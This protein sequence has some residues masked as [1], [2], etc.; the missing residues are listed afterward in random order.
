MLALN[1]FG[2]SLANKLGTEGQ[3]VCLVDPPP[4][5]LIIR[6]K[7]RTDTEQTE[8]P[9]FQWTEFKSSTSWLNL[10]TILDLT[11]TRE[12][13]P[14]CNR[15]IL[16]ISQC[17]VENKCWGQFSLDFSHYTHLPSRDIDCLCFELFFK[18]VCIA[19]CLRRVRKCLPQ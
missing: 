1:H 16:S 9:H 7:L 6:I 14:S 4:I 13:G 11:G 5:F 15:H 17:L 2:T 18:D 10:L 19:N 3:D 8:L 12:H